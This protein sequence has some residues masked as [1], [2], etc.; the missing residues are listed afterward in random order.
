M[1]RNLTLSLFLQILTLPAIAQFEY[2]EETHKLEHKNAIAVFVGNTIIAP[3]GFNLPTIGIEY[4][5][6]LNYFV[7]LG[8]ITEV[9][10]G[11]H[12]IQK[13]EQG[14]IVTEMEREGALLIAPSAFF[15]LQKGLVLSAGYGI[16]FEKT[17]NL[18]LLKISV[19]YEL[20]LEHPRWI[21]LPTISW[22][23]TKLF[24]G[25]VYGVNFGYR[26]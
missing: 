15:R 25:W 14:T 12:I 11:S 18:G 8:V 19:E 9:E 7:G 2:N 20:F 24:N 22:D 1:N 26:F 13:G 10:I 23:H 17:E 21:V 16:E 6:E 4:V 5:H 3:S